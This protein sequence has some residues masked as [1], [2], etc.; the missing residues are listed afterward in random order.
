MPIVLVLFFPRR[1]AWTLHVAKSQKRS[2]L[3]VLFFFRPEEG[4][5]RSPEEERR[6]DA[7]LVVTLVHWTLAGEG[8]LSRN[9]ERSTTL[10]T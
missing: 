5:T 9:G 8:T 7:S 10:F 2:V 3:V 1:L 6:F 4:G